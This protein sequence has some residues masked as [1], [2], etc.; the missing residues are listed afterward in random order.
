MKKYVS[1]L[2]VIMAG[3]LFIVYSPGCKKMEYVTSTTSDLNIYSYIKA[4]PAKY[5]SIT[6]IVEKSGYAGFLDAYGSYTMFVP[7]DSA[8]SIYLTEVGHRPA[9]VFV[10]RPVFL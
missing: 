1:A 9:F 5:S 2:L 7:T 4:D 6:K 3:L 8:V 10:Y